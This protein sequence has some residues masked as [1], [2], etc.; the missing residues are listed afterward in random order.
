MKIDRKLIFLIV[1]VFFLMI[2]L[3]FVFSGVLSA[4]SYTNNQDK[5]IGK[6]MI[7][8]ITIQSLV[9]AI[10]VKENPVKV[11]V[12]T[13]D[14]LNKI[15]NLKN[16]RNPFVTKTTKKKKVISSTPA[17]KKKK[18]PRRKKN[19][20]PSIAI[21]GIIWDEIKPFA[22]LNNKVHV[23]GDKFGDYRIY[24]ILDSLI[25]MSSEQ[26]TFKIKYK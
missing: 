16:I 19:K 24:A 5:Y 9:K 10:K 21:S 12:T 2:V 13:M 18:T 4:N 3:I 23:V 22:I 7:D 17:P 11:F 8:F 26:D 20:R 14:S 15:F 1:S 25:I 6:I